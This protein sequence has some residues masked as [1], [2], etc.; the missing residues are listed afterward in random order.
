MKLS[1]LLASAIV[2]F[3]S[4]TSNAQEIAGYVV[5]AESDTVRGTF[6]IAEVEAFKCVLTRNGNATTYTPQTASRFVLEDGRAFVSRRLPFG[7]TFE[8]LFAEKLVAGKM[9][10][11]RYQSDFFLDDGT[12]C[13]R[14]EK[15]ISTVQKDGFPHQLTSNKYQQVMS[16][17]FSDCPTVVKTLSDVNLEERP[18]R[19]AFTAYNK[20]VDGVSKDE[21]VATAKS[22]ITVGIE[23]GTGTTTLSGFSDDAKKY[24][25]NYFRVSTY[26]FPGIFLQLKPRASGF[27]S[28]VFAIQ[29]IS[30]LHEVRRD[31]TE[32]IVFND[33]IKVSYDDIKIPLYAHFELLRN[34]NFR[35]I[36]RI[37][38]AF[39]LPVNQVSERERTANLTTPVTSREPAFTFK[40]RG[41]SIMAEAG[42]EYEFGKLLVNARARFGRGFSPL[43]YRGAQRSERNIATTDINGI[44]AIGYMF[45]R[46]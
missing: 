2:I 41:V 38:A 22:T 33:H 26:S 15:I 14:L 19:K 3:I 18:L 27:A 45:T 8:Q 21:L 39:H 32:V 16:W 46:N 4:Y 23:L 12:D 31:Y 17:K 10:L 1:T 9:S 6:L 5:T 24:V 28:F 34:R 11:L 35:P 29:K 13:F 42:V 36:A 20:C 44:V 30:Y 43:Q 40:N 37:G 7:E 25:E